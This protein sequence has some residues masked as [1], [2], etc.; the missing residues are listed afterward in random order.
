[1]LGVWTIT[2]CISESPGVRDQTQERRLGTDGE[3]RTHYPWI[4]LVLLSWECP[5]PSSTILWCSPLEEFYILSPSCPDCVEGPSMNLEH[6]DL[7]PPEDWSLCMVVTFP[8]V[9]QLGCSCLWEEGLGL[10]H[11]CIPSIRFDTWCIIGW[12]NKCLL[13]NWMAG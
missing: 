10:F 12:L 8:V 13:K 2:P 11:Y 9:S 5:L 4:G 6:L 3:G 1:M 7:I